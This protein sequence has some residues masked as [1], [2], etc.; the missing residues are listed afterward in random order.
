MI[1][2]VLD[3]PM[4]DAIY[5]GII[6]VLVLILVVVGARAVRLSRTLKLIKASD[7]YFTDARARP[8]RA[9]PE[10]PTR[11]PT[12][13]EYT[14][15]V[16]A[17][18]ERSVA[19]GDA[20]A[21]TKLSQLDYR[22]AI[23]L[24][25]FA[26]AANRERLG[27]DEEGLPTAPVDAAEAATA[28]VYMSAGVRHSDCAPFNAA[29]RCLCRQTTHNRENIPELPNTDKIGQKVCE[30]F[31]NV[32]HGV[33]V[34]QPG[35]AAVKSYARLYEFAAMAGWMFAGGQSAAVADVRRVGSYLGS[36]YVLTD[37][38]AGLPPLRGAIV[39]EIGEG[40]VRDEIAK[41]LNAA[42]VV[43][44]DLELGTATWDELF[45]QLAEK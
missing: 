14:Q 37:D 29:L 24:L 35:V 41:H 22:A 3:A 26:R 30:E 31:A 23:V 20:P 25:E 17:L 6:V 10:N 44:K 33:Q 4:R 16:A 42:R 19:S 32:V 34:T 2:F 38:V 1:A 12:A 5:A 15:E 21:E 28:V 11:A 27:R 39:A 45:A 7:P 13:Q 40:A 43:L 18:V 36:A 8:L 9:K